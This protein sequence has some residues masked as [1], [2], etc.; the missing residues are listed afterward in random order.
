MLVLSAVFRVT[1]ISLTPRFFMQFSCRC[2]D[3][4]TLS[5]ILESPLLPSFLDI[6]FLRHLCDVRLYEFSCSLVQQLKFCHRRMVLSFYRGRLRGYWSYWWDFFNVVWLRE[7][8]SFPWGILFKIFLCMF[9]GGHFQYCQLF[10]GF[11]F[12]KRFYIILMR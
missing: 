1:L 8:F 12:S 5:L 6:I 2:I 11:H 7:D 10:I 9:D 4:S 3:S